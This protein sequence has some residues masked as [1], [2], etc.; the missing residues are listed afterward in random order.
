MDRSLKFALIVMLQ[1]LKFSVKNFPE[2]LG[3]NL[4]IGKSMV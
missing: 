4:V 2:K 3:K 1:Q